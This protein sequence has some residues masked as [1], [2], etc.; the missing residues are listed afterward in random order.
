MNYDPLNITSNLDMDD[1]DYTAYIYYL[2]DASAGDVTISLT[3][4]LW[5]GQTFYLNRTDT[6]SNNVYLTPKSG[7][8]LSNST[9]SLPLNVGQ[10]CILTSVGTNWTAPRI[11][12]T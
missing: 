9:S 1:S 4:Y 8:T 2:I 6:S 5:D 3:A 7:S 11:S 12:Y 10:M